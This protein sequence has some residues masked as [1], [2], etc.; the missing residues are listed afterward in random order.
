LTEADGSDAGA[1]PAVRRPVRVNAVQGLH[2][3]PAARIVE[4]ARRFRARVSLIHGDATVSAK[5]LLDVLYLAATHGTDLVVEAEGDD[6][7]A[8][9]TALADLFGSLRDEA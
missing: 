9:A 5:D 7:D 3:R 2:A 8:A 4:T 1:R 6:A